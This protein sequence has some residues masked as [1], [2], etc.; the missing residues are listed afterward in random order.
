LSTTTKIEHHGRMVLMTEELFNELI[1]NGLAE[2][3]SI[4]VYWHQPLSR[5]ELLMARQ[6][7]YAP[8]VVRV[9]DG[10]KE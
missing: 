3:E 8:H 4:T 1:N 10:N 9:F 2:D 5:R 7:I 6:R